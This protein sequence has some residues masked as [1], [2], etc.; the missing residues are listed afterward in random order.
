MINH[1][2]RLKVHLLPLIVQRCSYRIGHR[3]ILLNFNA[4]F[5][6]S[7][8]ESSFSL[9]KFLKVLMNI[10]LAKKCKFVKMI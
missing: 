3:L 8:I 9:R 5:A 6:N 4:I 2:A 10:Q 7:V 1:R